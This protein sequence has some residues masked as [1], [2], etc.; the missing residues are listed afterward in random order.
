M[1]PAMAIIVETTTR[2]QSNALCLRDSSFPKIFR[3]KD[4]GRIMQIVKQANEPS[5][6]MIRSNEG[7]RM[8]RIIN[9][10]VTTM[11]IAH[12]QIPRLNPERPSKLE[13]GPSERPSS[14]QNTSAVL[15]I[16][17]A[18]YREVSTT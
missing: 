13:A 12:F 5:R 4:A 11:R 14:P 16:G 18:L 15:T 17:R 6:D 8:A 2:V 10:T 3:W 7:I 9:T 1:V